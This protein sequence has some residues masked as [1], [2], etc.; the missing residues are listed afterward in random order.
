ML[1]LKIIRH[2]DYMTRKIIAINSVLIVI[3]TLIIFF[4]FIKP[5]QEDRAV[6]G[7]YDKT[8]LDSLT[9]DS[10]RKKSNARTRAQKLAFDMLS[11]NEKEE[12]LKK[13][14]IKVMEEIL[15]QSGSDIKYFAENHV[16]N[17]LVN[18]KSYH[19]NI[20]SNPEICLYKVQ[21]CFAVQVGY[22]TED[23][24]GGRIKASK[25]VIIDLTG[26]SIIDVLDSQK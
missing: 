5:Y 14:E 11:Y 6:L 12:I 17:N 9:L 26:K 19:N 1:F 7:Y 8:G 23:S 22:T 20:L 15:K 3:I 10:L 25:K 2:S 21:N 13:R 4:R 18:P 24:I 16:K